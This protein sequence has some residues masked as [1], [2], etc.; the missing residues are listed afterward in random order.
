MKLRI[1]GQQGSE[2][3]L[4][5]NSALSFD[6]PRTG[7]SDVPGA[8]MQFMYTGFVSL[9]VVTRL[10]IIASE[11]ESANPLRIPILPHNDHVLNNNNNYKDN[12][13]VGIVTAT[14]GS[15]MLPSAQ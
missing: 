5:G 13:N 11:N 12:N 9:V 15:V 14:V 2:C 1:Y 4:S 6:I 7:I 8:R 10:R 3:K